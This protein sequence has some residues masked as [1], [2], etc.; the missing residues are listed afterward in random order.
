MTMG[1]NDQNQGVQSAKPTKTTTG[2]QNGG[3]GDK[4]AFEQ[5]MKKL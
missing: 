2:G 5:Y 3:R 1:R 4:T